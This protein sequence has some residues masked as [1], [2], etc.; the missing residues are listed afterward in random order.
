MT[1]ESLDAWVF[2]PNWETPIIEGLEFK[3]NILTS[4]WGAEQ[5]IAHRDTPRRTFE[6]DLTVAGGERPHMEQFIRNNGGRRF[7]MPIFVDRYELSDDMNGGTSEAFMDTDG[8]MIAAGDVIMVKDPNS[9]ECDLY[10][11][12]SFTSTKINIVG[13]TWRYWPAGSFVYK[14]QQAQFVDQIALDE[15]GHSA[16]VGAVKVLIMDSNPL[17]IQEPEVTGPLI[18]LGR[19][20]VSHSYHDMSDPTGRSEEQFMM[21]GAFLAA[22]DAL[23]NDDAESADYYFDRAMEI[24]SDTAL[25]LGDEQSNIIRSYWADDPFSTLPHYRFAARSNAAIGETTLDQTFEVNADNSL[26]IPD[27]YATGD[28]IERVWKIYPTTAKL[29]IEKPWSPA[30][31]FETPTVDVSLDITDWSITDDGI[32][33]PL[34]VEADDEIEEWNLVYTYENGKAID[35][36]RAF[37]L[38]PAIQPTRPFTSIY[39]GEMHHWT[40]RTLSR[41]VT[42]LNDMGNWVADYYEGMLD[43]WRKSDLRARRIDDQRWIFEPMPLVDPIPSLDD[44]PKGFFCY[45]N[46]SSASAP[47]GTFGTDADWTGYNFWSR[48][49]NG[50]WIAETDV[51]DAL[52]RVQIGRNFSDQ[53]RQA[54][55]FQDADQYLYVSVSCTRKP[56][57]ANGEYFLVWASSKDDD[58]EEDRWFADIGSLAPFVATSLASGTVIEF[59]IPLA[60]L[61]RRTYNGAGV[62]VW[63]SAM[64]AGQILKSFGISAEFNDN[65]GIRLRGMRLLS[66]SSAAWVTSNLTKAKKGYPMAYA[67]GVSPTL[68]T[69]HIDQQRFTG[70]NFSPLHGYQFPEFWKNAEAEANSIFAGLT[71]NDLPIPDRTTNVIGYPITATT[72]VGA[73]AKTPAAMLMEQQL[74]FLDHAQKEYQA[75]GGTLGPFAHT[76]TMNTYDRFLFNDSTHSKWVYE[77]ARPYTQWGGFQYRIAEGLAQTIDTI[78]ATAAYSDSK[79]LATTILTN[80]MTWLNGAWPNL[81]GTWAGFDG[82]RVFSGDEADFAKRF[83]GDEN[84]FLENYEDTLT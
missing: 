6:I 40:E 43:S 75:D 35:I 30:Y 16:S 48:D 45:S 73:V 26:V 55:S 34:P 20:Y 13:E 49:T 14:V 46:H 56:V 68:V 41:A 61:K 69:L 58:T 65:I 71:V 5:R 60:N 19:F 59:L 78:G 83:S 51:P 72:S 21:G 9:H 70:P 32:E 17:I 31:D 33:V 82:I 76:Y 74:R 1:I 39:A 8:M 37:E 38:L 12:D 11:V 47:I 27:Y 25:G 53:W 77:N 79:T 15:I 67:P 3:T 28:S 63:G 81:T 29:F 2:E 66:G 80:F 4:K 22:Y 64:P 24:L 23:K 18:T 36:G 50:D 57:L 52:S 84:P 7:Y 10:E 62:S 54:A 42:I 44:V